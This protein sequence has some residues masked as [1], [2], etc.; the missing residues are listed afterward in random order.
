M[1]KC[2]LCKNEMI[3]IRG[4]KFEETYF[5]EKCDTIAIKNIEL[6]EE[7]NYYRKIKK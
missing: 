7:V 1:I 5:C 4:D 3:Y 6:F 2:I